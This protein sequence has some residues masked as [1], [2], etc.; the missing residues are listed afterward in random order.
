MIFFY[1]RQIPLITVT[2]HKKE[3]DVQKDLTPDHSP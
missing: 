3:Q 2:I 1:K